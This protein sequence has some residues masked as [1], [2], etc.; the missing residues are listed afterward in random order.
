MKFSKYIGIALLAGSALSGCGGGSS[1]GG[2]AAPATVT[3]NA[4][5]Q[6]AIAKAAASLGT[7]N[8]SGFASSVGG[9]QTSVSTG[10]DRMLFNFADNVIQ[11]LEQKKQS[12]P[13][14]VAGIAPVPTTLCNISGS[15][16]IDTDG[17]AGTSG[18]YMY[19]TANNCEDF[20]GVIE[21]GT[22]KISGINSSSG[23]S[24]TLDLN[25]TETTNGKIT[26]QAIGGFTLL[27]T[28]KGTATQVNTLSGTSLLFATDTASVTLTGAPGASGFN[29]TDT[30]NNNYTTPVIHST[31]IGFTVAFTD[32]VTPTNSFSFSEQ[33]TAGKPFVK[34]STEGYLRSGQIVV[35]GA[36]MTAI[37]VTILP[38][39][40]A[41]VAG[42][43]TGQLTI[44]LSTDG[45][46]NWG[47][48]V[49]KTWAT[50]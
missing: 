10:S 37:R 42:T 36:S 34:Y 28:G 9:V 30:F 3:I 41:N 40:G 26:L 19:A 50:L 27:E 45:G 20:A 33:T 25:F 14:S 7:Q 23:F 18:T 13:A 1:N 39:S 32:K 8:Y 31:V 4:S 11:K 48:P 16:S 12:V 24:A 38:T 22:V 21:S 35:V 47:T 43:S 44:E 46:T 49:T 15:Y 17:T 5:N 6:A 29:F 2:T